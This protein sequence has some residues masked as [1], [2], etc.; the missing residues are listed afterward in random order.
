MVLGSYEAP[1]GVRSK[2]CAAPL[3]VKPFSTGGVWTAAAAILDEEDA[4]SKCRFGVKSEQEVATARWFLC[5][6]GE[7]L[8]SVDMTTEKR[9]LNRPESVRS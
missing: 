7:Q 4:R 5:L 1:L 3:A 6:L 2:T 8:W 9:E